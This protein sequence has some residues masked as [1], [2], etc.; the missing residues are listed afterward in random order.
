MASPL[1]IPSFR[2]WF[3]A[4][5]AAPTVEVPPSFDLEAYLSSLVIAL[6]TMIIYGTS[7]FNKLTDKDRKNIR[8]KTLL[9]MPPS[10]MTDTDF[11]HATTIYLMGLTAVFLLVLFLPQSLLMTTI[12]KEMPSGGAGVQS[13]ARSLAA[14]RAESY[15]LIAALAF[16]GMIPNIPV[17][18]RIEESWRSLVQASASVPKAFIDVSNLIDNAVAKLCDDKRSEEL[19]TP[20]LAL[21]LLSN[22]THDR[23]AKARIET[24]LSGLQA[25]RLRKA[26]LLMIVIVE[27]NNL[28]Q[29]ERSCLNLD[30]VGKSD[31]KYVL[32]KAKYKSLLDVIATRWN[33]SEPKNDDISDLDE[34][35]DKLIRLGVDIIVSAIIQ[36]PRNISRSAAFDAVDRA[37]DQAVPVNTEETRWLPLP[38]ESRKFR[39]GRDAFTKAFSVAILIPPVIIMLAATLRT[40]SGSH[41]DYLSFPAINEYF[42]RDV[43]N[44]LVGYFF[45]TVP[46]FVSIFW[47][48][49]TLEETGR[50]TITVV[51]HDKRGKPERDKY[52]EQSDVLMG[53]LKVF[54]VGQIVVIIMMIFVR[55]FNRIQMESFSVDLLHKSISVFGDLKWISFALTYGAFCSVLLYVAVERERVFTRA[56]YGFYFLLI[57]S[58]IA[59]ASLFSIGEVADTGSISW[60]V[61]LGF[62]RH[63]NLSCYNC[64]TEFRLAVLTYAT[65]IIFFAFCIAGTL[66]ARWRMERLL[67]ENVLLSE[68]RAWRLRKRGTVCSASI[69]SWIEQRRSRRDIDRV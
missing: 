36:R 54:V 10:R 42:G 3:E 16:F 21:K 4:L 62:S 51:T 12:P 17:L 58:A 38:P 19:Y 13:G 37:F 68:W 8:N 48:R 41:P 34:Q 50:W 49:R 23:T 63:S 20:D 25:K 7:S 60:S 22:S 43:V 69:T 11:L 15:P 31:E 18:A 5:W 6:I 56:L 33:D 65:N 2:A 35:F 40:L 14:F 59:N 39:I 47:Y 57:F 44:T 26:F 61:L 29:I 66:R 52:S 1:D 55:L 64:V 53:Y 46:P 24:M 45:Y 9:A 67:G 30:V 27:L 28:P 32:F